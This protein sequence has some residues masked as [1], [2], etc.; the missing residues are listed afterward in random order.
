MQLFRLL[1]SMDRSR[2][3]INGSVVFLH[4]QPFKAHYRDIDS[5]AKYTEKA[6]LEKVNSL[7]EV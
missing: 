5:A 3:V 7:I 6:G 1:L 4:H 2:P